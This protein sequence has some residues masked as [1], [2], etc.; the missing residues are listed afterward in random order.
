ME[1]DIFLDIL[2]SQLS[3]GARNHTVYTIATMI[4]DGKTEEAKHEYSRDGDKVGDPYKYSVEKL[5]GC[6]THGVIDCTHHF[7]KPLEKVT[8]RPYGQAI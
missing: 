1:P 8:A 3:V 5:I 4:R 7:C 6:R 2:F